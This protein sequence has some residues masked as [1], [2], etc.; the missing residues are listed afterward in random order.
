MMYLVMAYRY[1]DVK[2]YQFPVGIFK[3][4]D[5]AIEQAH[6]HRQFRGYKYDHKLFPMEDGISYDAEECKGE[7]ITGDP[8]PAPVEPPTYDF[9]WECNE[10]GS[11]EFTSAFPEKLIDAEAVSCTNCGG[12]EF[13][14]VI[15]EKSC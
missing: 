3:D 12:T 15:V 6:A 10:C 8:V 1:G 4:R 14:K 5:V 9:C 2:G 11:Q 13:H 7:W